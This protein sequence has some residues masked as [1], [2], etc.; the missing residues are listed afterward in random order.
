MGSRRRLSG[1]A[2]GLALAAAGWLAVPDRF[3]VEGVSMGPALLPRDTVRTGPFPAFDRL[4]RPRRFDRWV[5]A[6]TD[7]RAIKRVVGLPGESVAIVA[8][9]LAID[10]RTILKG[11]RVLAEVGSTVPDDVAAE[12]GAPGWAWS[13]PGGEILDDA[14]FADG[15]TRVLAA[16]RDVGLAAVVDARAA[17]AADPAEVRLR[18]GDTVVA[19]PL[20]AAGRHA[21]VAG[22]LDGW[23][24]VATWPVADAAGPAGGRSCLPPGPPETWAVAAP[25]PASGGDDAP[26]LAIGGDRVIVAGVSRWRDVA[27]RPGAD[28]RTS[29][30]LGAEEVFV[31]GDYPA[32]ST[33]SRQWGPVATAAL[34][35]RI[36]SD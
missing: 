18:V 15:P 1:A 29:W 32:A 3:A 25:W 35:Q 8:G 33:D 34:R 21:V 26:A 2:A 20:V 13:R 31:L 23:L 14:A 28:D 9:D 5:L 12:P 24:V 36:A 19:R 17:S 27:W 6:A 4:R 11:P 22:R 30:R 7:G 10:G 16:V